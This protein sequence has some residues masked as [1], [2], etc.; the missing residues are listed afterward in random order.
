MQKYNDGLSCIHTQIE[1]NFPVFSSLQ[2]PQQHNGILHCLSQ[3]I[4]KEA[5]HK[6]RMTPQGSKKKINA[7]IGGYDTLHGSKV[8]TS[9]FLFSHCLIAILLMISEYMNTY[10]TQQKHVRESGNQFISS[11]TTNITPS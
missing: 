10:K 3:H 6:I 9:H 8:I 5:T 4:L 7:Q 2:T 1:V 11:S